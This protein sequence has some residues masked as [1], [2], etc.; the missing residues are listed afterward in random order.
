[1]L[2]VGAHVYT[3]T[4]LRA[5]FDT[6]VQNIVKM[7][8]I[9]SAAG[10][11]FL[12]PSTVMLKLLRIVGL[13]LNLRNGDDMRRLNDIFGLTLDYASLNDAKIEIGRRGCPRRGLI[14]LGSCLN[15]GLKL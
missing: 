3:F 10:K 11:K 13:V 4:K 6:S 2:D 8:N 5:E 1:M 12:V 14:Y 7:T 9:L 15:L